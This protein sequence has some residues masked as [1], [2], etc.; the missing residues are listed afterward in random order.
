MRLMI[1][2]VEIINFIEKTGGATIQQISKLFFPSYDMAKKRLKK[3][4]LMKELKSEIQPILGKKVYYIKKIPSYH[5][6]IVTDIEIAFRGYTKLFKREYEIAG[7]KV[8]CLLTLKNGKIIIFEIDIYNRTKRE[9]L[10]KITA[11]LAKNGIQADCFVVT[12][13]QRRDKWEVGVEEVEKV[14]RQYCF[15]KQS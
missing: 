10:N 13:K 9:R 2:D 8:D 4:E 3:L 6:L 12:K 11:T 7:Q 14:S 5:R 1:R 15:N